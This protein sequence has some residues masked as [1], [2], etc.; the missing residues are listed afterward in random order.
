MKR[1]TLMA[2]LPL[3]AAAAPAIMLSLTTQE[4]LGKKLFFDSNL[5][6]PPGQSCATCHGPEVG[7][8]GPHALV[9]AN[10]AVYEGAVHMR[11]G[12]RKPPSSAYAS[13]SPPFQY[14][15]D[16]DTF[17]GGQF[18]DG[19][20][21]T[22]VDQ[23]KG[24]FLNPL[25]QNN[26]NP[27][28]VVQKVSKS[29]Y[30]WMFESVY[31]PGGID[32]VKDVM[33]SYQRIAEAIAAYEAS[34]ESDAFTSKFDAYVAGLVE[35]TALEA[36]GL[37]EFNEYCGHC[38]P[39]TPGPYSVKALFTDYTYDNVG[40]PRNPKNLFYTMN[41]GVNPLGFNWVD[42][43][44]Y[45]TTG[46]PEDMG[47]MKVPTLRNVDKR[48][49]PGF[50]KAYGHNGFFKSLKEIVHFYNTRDVLPWPAPEV[51]VNVNSELLTGKP[52]GNLELTEEQEDA[53]VAFLKTL[54]DGY[55]IPPG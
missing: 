31:G 35:L 10:E 28:H 29:D 14:D 9:N 27:K 48:P 15:P 53:I 37:D 22:L 12:G 51:G 34:A 6:T 20:A 21:S 47:K 19:R 42:L 1:K 18:W 36:E 32:P 38:H 26:P 30:A 41:K 39:S 55:V 25:E 8:T 24:P 16:E 52:L 54:S 49:Y 44:L 2:A 7:W 3:L 45:F 4:E 5:S 43:G 50:V 11:W 33:G 23:A 17:F 13:F 40:T 46:R